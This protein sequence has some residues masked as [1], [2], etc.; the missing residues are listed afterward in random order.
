[1]GKGTVT[2]V[3]NVGGKEVH[4]TFSN[5]LH[6]PTLSANLVSVSQLDAMGC[7]AT[8]G[9]GGVVIREGSAGEIILE[10]HGSAGMYVLEAT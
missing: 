8:F 3:F 5:A 2:K 4:I 9:A 10:G 1:I 7:Y 6:A